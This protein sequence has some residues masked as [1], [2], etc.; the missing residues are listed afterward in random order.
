MKPKYPLYIPSKGRW[1]SRLT[2]KA[3]HKMGVE[4][5]VIVEPNEVEVYKKHLDDSATI[6]E[7]DLDYKENYET[8]DNLGNSISYGSGPARNYARDHSEKAGH[9]WHWIMDDNIRSFKRLQNNKR[10][11]VND[12]AF[13]YAMEDF[14]ERYENIAMAGPNYHT[15]VQSKQKYK[16]FKMNTR[17]YSCNFIRNDL[18]Y[19]WTARRNEDTI[20][21]LAML[22]DGWCTVLFNA[23]M[24][25]KTASQAMKGG[26]TDAFYGPEGTIPKSQTLVDLHPDVAKLSWRWGR[27]HHFV[28][29]T[30]FKKNKLRRK[31]GLVIP[32]EAN[33]FG[34]I[35]ETKTDDEWVKYAA[36]SSS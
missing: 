6:L 23:F 19:R 16:P 32:K 1:E 13:F 25:E 12:G 29:Y 20:L 28:D 30:P 7:L 34:M 27:A 17:I 21:S 2:S 4:H 36:P 35:L 26:N 11:D 33:N 18:P 3:L 5:Y 24:Q 14:C 22:K 8:F 15:F 9:L 10:I 31:K